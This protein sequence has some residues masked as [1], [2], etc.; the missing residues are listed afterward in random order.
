M[1]NNTVIFQINATGNA[2]SVIQQIQQYTVEMNKS[3]S[4][5]TNIFKSFGANVIVFQQLSQTLSGFRDSLN[6]AIAPGVAFDKSLHELSAIAQVTGKPLEEIGQ[7]ARNLAKTFGGEASRYVESFKDVIG[8]LGDTFSDSTA[9]DMMGKNIATLSKLMGG[10]AKAAADALTTAMLQYGVDLKNPVE[11]SRE[12]TRMMNVMQAAANVGGSEVN[13]TA[14]AL[15]QAGLLAKQSG[16]SFEELNA[17][18]EGLAK[19][20]IVAGEAGTAMRNML[21]SMSTL[22]NGSKDVREGLAKYGVN[23]GLVMD[24]T[25]KFTDRLRELSKIQNDPALMESVFLKANIAAGQTLLNNIDTIDEWTDAVSGTNAAV[26]GAATVMESYAEKQERIRAKFEDLKISLFNLTG[27]FGI[28]T[29]IVVSSLVPLAQMIPLINGIGGAMSW[30]KSLNFAG[31]IA[32]ATTSV[33]LMNMYLAE[34]E[35]VAFGFGQKILQAAVATVRFATVG[36]FNAVKGLGA[37]VISLITGGTTSVTFSAIASGAFATFATS[38]RVAC[39]AVST[40]IYSIPIIGWIALAIAA[41][42]SLFV[43]LYNKFDKFAAFANA[44]WAAIKAVFTGGNF[45]DAFDKEY[46]RTIAERAAERAKESVKDDPL[47][48]IHEQEE[49]LKK[50]NTE[51]K[52]DNQLGINNSVNNV[53][54]NSAG[55][56]KIKNINITI[57]RVI[58]KFEVKTTHLSESV[59]RIKDMVAEAVIEGINDVNLAY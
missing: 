16:L 22:S 18:L 23:V 15:R 4:K 46:A 13:D 14:Q 51:L 32:G 28:W 19:G 3:L 12:A 2:T 36:I 26:E 50:S 34:G 59:G 40:A 49:A 17:S 11:A 20:K 31:M 30:V 56:N 8:S 10:D 48:Q 9:L 7:K 1:A 45:G 5:T 54:K 42:A 44:T 25:V 57:D 21:L 47:A 35:L 27:D 55:D 41:I 39:A 33:R 29:E 58:E 43:W 53:S 24:P 6:S 52:L 38:A 37:F